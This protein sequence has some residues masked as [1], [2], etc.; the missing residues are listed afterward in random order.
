MTSQ[1]PVWTVSIHLLASYLY[2]SDGLR[3]YLFFCCVYNYASS[4]VYIIALAGVCRRSE[5]NIRITEGHGAS[6]TFAH[7]FN[8]P[9]S[10][11]L[12]DRYGCCRYTH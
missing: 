10:R 4:R 7:V 6:L 11:V 5:L 8:T 12:K 3:P 2:Q 9:N 1:Y